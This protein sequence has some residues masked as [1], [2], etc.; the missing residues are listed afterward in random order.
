[1]W[2]QYK[3]TALLTQLFIFAMAITLYFTSGRRWF[4][5]LVTFLTMQIGAVFGAMWGARLK[6]K[7]ERSRERLPLERK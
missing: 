5:A 3:K 1:M 4:I 6:R 2:E 7:L